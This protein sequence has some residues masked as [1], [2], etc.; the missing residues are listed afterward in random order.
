[1]SP[2]EAALGQLAPAAG[3]LSRERVLFEAGRASARPGRTWPLLAGASSLLASV[4][5]LVLLTRPAQVV[6]HTVI[7]RVAQP[8][9]PPSPPPPEPAADN[10]LVEQTE[11]TTD[12]FVSGETD[13]LR[14]REEVLRW[15]VDRLPAAAPRSPSSTPLTPAE[16]RQFSDLPSKSSKLF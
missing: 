14:R 4:L 13:Y 5:A 1:M 16:L 12:F 8:P 2:L 11:P 9:A 10:P 7:V 15:G 6:E 3:A